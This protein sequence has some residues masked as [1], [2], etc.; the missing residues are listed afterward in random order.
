M[1]PL[2]LGLWLF[3]IFVHSFRE[4][5]RNEIFRVF[6]LPEFNSNLKSID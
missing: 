1:D 6:K 5:L 2:D 4:K 3:F